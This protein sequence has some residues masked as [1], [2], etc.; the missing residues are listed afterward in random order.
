MW[1]KKYRKPI[2]RKST[3][4]SD[5][6]KLRDV[7]GGITPS[8]L[9]GFYSGFGSWRIRKEG[10]LKYYGGFKSWWE[11]S[12]KDHWFENFIYFMEVLLPKDLPPCWICLY[13]SKARK[14][15]TGTLSLTYT[16][17]F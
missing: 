3:E 14:A 7:A 13:K 8:Q 10:G 15:L 4:T 11:E 17:H 5:H 16:T 12:Y 6:E 2:I 9:S 1:R